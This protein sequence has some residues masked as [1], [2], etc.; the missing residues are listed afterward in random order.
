[1]KHSV[2]TLEGSMDRLEDARKT[3]LPLLPT[4][5]GPEALSAFRR[6]ARTEEKLERIQRE[7]WLRELHQWNELPGLG[8]KLH[9]HP[10]RNP[11]PN[12]PGP[13]VNPEMSI[14]ELKSTPFVL[15]S[16]GRYALSIQVAKLGTEAT[17]EKKIHASWNAHWTR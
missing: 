4:P 10:A 2:L 15:N 16:P 5:Q 9:D 7:E 8:C 11:Y 6:V 14:A 12:F 13:V 3:L 17:L 1:M